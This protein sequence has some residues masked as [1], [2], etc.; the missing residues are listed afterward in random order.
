MAKPV[1]RQ[2]G[3]QHTPMPEIPSSFNQLDE[4]TIADLEDLA[5][6]SALVQDMVDSMDGVKSMCETRDELENAVEDIAKKNLARR[7]E[8]RAVESELQATRKQLTEQ[9]VLFAQLVARQ[10]AVMAKHSVQQLVR[11]L[12]ASIEAAEEASDKLKA[13]YESQDQED[14]A[15]SGG[16]SDDEKGDG[17]K[18]KSSGKGKAKAGKL[19][20][21]KFCSEYVKKRALVHMRLAKKERL[22]E[23]QRGLPVS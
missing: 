17:D 7:D 3:K 23:T 11:A 5:R 9:Q 1:S 14:G 12:D 19:S 18:D 4:K 22:L 15:E 21:S 8:L 13:Q 6:S 10:Q 2:D 16:D 20:H